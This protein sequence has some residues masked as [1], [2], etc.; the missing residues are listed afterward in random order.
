MLDAAT[1]FIIFEKGADLPTMRE[2]NGRKPCAGTDAAAVVLMPSL[3]NGVKD[4]VNRY[5]LLL[6]VEVDVDVAE[7]DGGGGMFCNELGTIM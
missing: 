7:E 4:M 1:H 6:F 2:G 3:L 5:L